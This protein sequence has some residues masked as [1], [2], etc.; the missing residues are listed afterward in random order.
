MFVAFLRFRH[1]LIVYTVSRLT[2]VAT[3]IS[4]TGQEFRM[5][6][7]PQGQ[8]AG[9][10]KGV[11]RDGMGRFEY[12]NGNRYIGSWERGMCV[13]MI[14]S[15]TASGLWQLSHAYEPGINE[16]NTFEQT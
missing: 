12:S 14:L 16:E 11:E 5:K 8:Y 13:S 15:F 9:E 1:R 3:Q 6:A 7:F 10:F 2:A 4:S